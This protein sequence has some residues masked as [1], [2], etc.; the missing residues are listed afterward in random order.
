MMKWIRNPIF[1]Y[2]IYKLVS[3]ASRR[4]N[5]FIKVAYP[6]EEK[7]QSVQII[8]I[9]MWLNLKLPVLCPHERLLRREPLFPY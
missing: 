9:S 7:Q 6:N 2:P 8:T 4:D 1:I 3:N 5:V